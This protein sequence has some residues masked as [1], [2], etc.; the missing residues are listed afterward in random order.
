MKD[1]RLSLDYRCYSSPL[2]CI[3]TS[4]RSSSTMADIRHIAELVGIKDQDALHE[5]A[6]IIQAFLRSHNLPA[7]PDVP[8][9]KTLSLERLSPVHY[10]ILEHLSY[11]APAKYLILSRYHYKRLIPRIYRHVT[12]NTNILDACEEN[13]GRMFQLLGH[14]ETLKFADLTTLKNICSLKDDW[15]Y[16]RL[17][18]NTKR[19]E[20]DAQMLRVYN[21]DYNLGPSGSLSVTLGDKFEELVFRF[22][23]VPKKT[24]RLPRQAFDNILGRQPDIVTL[25]FAIPYKHCNSWST[26]LEYVPD[27]LEGC[28][29]GKLCKV[30]FDIPKGKRKD[31][32]GNLTMT[33]ARHI[34]RHLRSPG[35]RQVGWKIEYHVTAAEEFSAVIW[36]VLTEMMP[37]DG[38][39][40]DF[41]GE[42]CEFVELDREKFQFKRGVL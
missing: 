39:L 41:F 7:L 29:P 24:F 8:S 33:V 6:D 1:F 5:F 15:L 9:S 10:L 2:Q 20:I 42:R 11:M 21:N 38:A 36:Q 13:Y 4:Q 23:Q 40:G 22:M 35:A 12:I 3:S 17:F 37:N 18:H 25:I 16:S 14:I 26:L 28:E 27:Y 30:V 19:I 34:M 31:L 32:R